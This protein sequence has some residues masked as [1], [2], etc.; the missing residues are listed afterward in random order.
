MRKSFS[1]APWLFPQPVTIIAAYDKDG[2]V[3][4]MNAAWVGTLGNTEI[5]AELTPTHK[6][7]KNFRETGAFTLAIGDAAHE[8]EC[9]FLG[10]VSGNNDSEKFA[11][12]GFTTTKSDVVNA[13]LINELPFAME[14]TVKSYDPEKRILIGEIKGISADESVLGDDGTIDP[15]KLDAIVFDPIKHGYYKLGEKAGDAFKDGL[16]SK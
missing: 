14:C 5:I 10:M 7:V 4:A 2:N 8:W 15:E 11:K 1:P 16:K 3:N 6:T 12:T 9:D 13:P